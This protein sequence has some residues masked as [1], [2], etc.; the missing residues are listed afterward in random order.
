MLNQVTTKHI[1]GSFQLTLALGKFYLAFTS[2]LVYFLHTFEENKIDLRGV[3][4]TLTCLDV[5]KYNG[6]Q[7]IAGHILA[8]TGSSYIGM[9]MKDM[10]TLTSLLLLN[11]LQHHILSLLEGYVIVILLPTVKESRWCE[12]L[13]K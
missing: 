12:I 5:L 3:K 10:H 11:Q 1:E 7:V 4:L 2:D 9:A 13:S 6:E 8:Q